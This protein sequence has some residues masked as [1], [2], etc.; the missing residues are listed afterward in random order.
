MIVSDKTFLKCFANPVI[1]ADE[2]KIEF[3]LLKLKAG[4]DPW[5]VRNELRTTLEDDVQVMTKQEF[6]DQVIHY[7][8]TAQPVGYVFGMGMLVGFLIGVTICYQILFTDIMDHAPQYATLKA[9]G[10]SNGYL[11][12]LVLWQA[13]YL[14]LMGFFPGL[15]ASLAAYSLLQ[16]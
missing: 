11:I 14:A 10:Y 15:L 8:A 16:A 3:G 4:A 7:W 12:R 6:I 5:K 1:G 2:R 13:T 9:I